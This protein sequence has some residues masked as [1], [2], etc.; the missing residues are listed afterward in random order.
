MRDKKK[1]VSIMDKKTTFF[2]YF[3]H[4][5]IFH[6]AELFDCAVNF[7]FYLQIKH[8]RS[9]ILIKKQP[10]ILGSVVR[11]DFAKA[12]A[13]NVFSEKGVVKSFPKLTGKHLCWSRYFHKVAGF[14]PVTLSKKRLQHRCFPINFMNFL[15]TP[16]FKEHLRWLLFGLEV[17]CQACNFSGVLSF[18]SVFDDFDHIFPTCFCRISQNFICKKTAIL[19][20]EK[21]TKILEIGK[22]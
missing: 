21:L 20:N 4:G 8:Q 15:R 9:N 16:F 7:K 12:V 3:Y 6:S 14:W 13:P 22:F 11:K 19:K 10:L 2:T 5:I 1:L 17:K 18:T